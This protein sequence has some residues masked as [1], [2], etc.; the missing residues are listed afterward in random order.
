METANPKDLPAKK[1]NFSEWY[2]YVVFELNLLK[3]Y[4]VSGCYVMMPTATKFWEIIQSHLDK[5]FK[6]HDVENVYFPLLISEYNLSREESHIDGFKAEVAWVTHEKTEDELKLNNQNYQN[7]QNNQNNRLAIRPTSECAFYPTFQ[8]IIK[9]HA[10]LPLKYNQWCNVVRWEFSTPTP[11]VRSREFLWNEGHCAFSS[12]NE[13]HNNAIDM[14]N[15]YKHFYQKVL[16][17]PVICGKKTTGEKFAGAD[18]TFT[19]ETFIPDAGKGI[20]CAT[21]HNLGQNFSKMF[22]IKFQQNDQNGGTEF[23][24]QTSWGC[25]TRSIGTMIM[26]H[27]DDK[28]LVLPSEIATYHIVIVPIYSKDTEIIINEYCQNVTNLLKSFGLRVQYDN[29]SRRPGWKYNYWE[30][31]GIPL[32]FEIGKKEAGELAVMICR[33]DTKEKIKIPLNTIDEIYMKNLLSDYDKKLY[34]KAIYLIKN[35]TIKINS[36]KDI[37]NNIENIDVTKLYYGNLCEN[38]DCEKIIKQMKIKPQCRPDNESTDLFGFVDTNKKCCV[39]QC[40]TDLVC[41]ISRGF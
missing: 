4:D 13:A 9:S 28:G 2:R 38:I 1:I 37:G 17:V 15:V 19:I 5:E 11:F 40:D 41:V 36:I 22:D 14:I 12:E 30:E 29:T 34:E 6:K 39:C 26:T 7:N 20:Q 16:R 3:Y 27:G 33:R 25:T 21:S 8:T 35:S 23:V 24:H 31:R 32:R 10:D 18:E